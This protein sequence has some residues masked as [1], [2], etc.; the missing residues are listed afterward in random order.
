MGDHGLWW[1]NA[2]YDCSAKVPLIVSWPNRWC[3]GERRTE[4]CS[5]LDVIQ[6]IG[7][8]GKADVPEDWD[9]QSMVELLNKEDTP[10]RDY[11][12]SE[13]YAHNIGAGHC[14]IRKGQY[15]YVYFNKIDDN[16][17][18]ERQLFNM[19]EDPQE[20]NNLIEDEAYD[21]LVEELHAL[22]VKELGRE[23]REIEKKE[24]RDII[25]GQHCFDR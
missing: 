9:G 7:D 6:T 18:V 15:K 13:Y 11:A 17:G 21:E 3:G 5:L 14:M 23:P 10:W 20:F 4:V 22:L 19:I 2:M 8:I 24:S 16:N 25:N 12:V 1:K